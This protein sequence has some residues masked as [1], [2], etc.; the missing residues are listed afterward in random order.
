MNGRFKRMLEPGE[1]ILVRS[2]DGKTTWYLAG[3]L[4]LLAVAAWIRGVW[5]TEL[6]GFQFWKATLFFLAFAPLVPAVAWLWTRWK[7]VITDRRVLKRYGMFSPEIGEMRNE[8]VDKVRLDD[9]TLSVHGRDYRWEFSIS[10]NFLHADILYD[11]FGGRFDDPGLPAGPIADMLEPGETVLWRYSPLVT[12]LLPWVVLISGPAA[13]LVE[14]MWPETQRYLYFSP[15]LLL[16]PYVV[17]LEDVV[18]AWRRRGWQAVLTDRRLLRRRTESPLRCDAVPLDSVTEAYW[19]SKGWEL[20]VV[21][22]G[23]RDTIFCLPWTARRILDALERND[24]GEAM[25]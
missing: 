23:R 9:R 17:L 2:T 6:F 3:G 10:R 14:A 5:G 19:D 21:S 18:G 20:V 24:R 8:T 7:W 12:D 13:V 22:P 16:G 15:G 4:L 25:A 1:R 11:L